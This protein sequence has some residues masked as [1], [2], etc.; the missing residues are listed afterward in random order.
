MKNV[1]GG[2]AYYARCSVA[3]ARAGLGDLASIKASA[4]SAS[5]HAEYGWNN[6]VGVDASVVRVDGN[7]GPIQAGVGLNVDTHASIGANGLSVSFLGM[8]FSIGPRLSIQTPF[9][10]FSVSL[11]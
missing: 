5:A 4:I 1:L 11:F 8:G 7:L 2:E 9:F 3:E 6:S 10:D